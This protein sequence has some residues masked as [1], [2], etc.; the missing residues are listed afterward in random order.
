MD[1]YEVLV[2]AYVL[3]IS[4]SRE[5]EVSKFKQV[6]HNRIFFVFCCFGSLFCMIPTQSVATEKIIAFGDS[7]TAGWPY[8]TYDGNGCYNCGGY[9][10]YLQNF[11]VEAGRDAA[12]FNYGVPGE[13][14]GDGYNRI[15]G[16]MAS[17]FPEYVLLMEG[18]NDLTFYVDPG[19]VAYM[20]YMMAWRVV[21]WGGKPIV[22]T[23]TPDTRYGL[24]WKNVG[25]AN[26]WIRYYVQNDPWVCLSDQSVSAQ[27]YWGFTT[28][29]GLHP[30]WWGY[31][32]MA[33]TWYNDVTT[34][35]QC[36][37]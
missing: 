4:K 11:F 36:G 10:P 12:V 17:T 29:D 35:K 13:M 14:T 20:V 16:V 33:Q 9:E 18:T 1:E 6:W 22:A 27:P 5:T 25:I 30:N 26:N 3:S 2:N 7:I 19:T 28:Y 34:L 37:Y 23:I 21:L 32:V 24:D 31:W 8:Q 15:D